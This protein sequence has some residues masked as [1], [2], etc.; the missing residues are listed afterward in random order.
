MHGHF[1]GP[2]DPVFIPASTKS[3]N[4][5]V[6]GDKRGDADCES[7]HTNKKEP[8][9]DVPQGQRA[10]PPP[11][12]AAAAVDTSCLCSGHACRRDGCNLGPSSDLLAGHS[13]IFKGVTRAPSTQYS[14]ESLR[15]NVRILHQYLS[16]E[17]PRKA[18]WL[19]QIA[20]A[21]EAAGSASLARQYY[22][23][24]FQET[25]SRS[26]AAW[27]MYSLSVSLHDE[28]D[29]PGVV[30][31]ASQGISKAPSP[32]LLWIASL[33]SYNMNNMQQA[34]AWAK[35]A[36]SLGCLQQK[37][38]SLCNIPSQL[39]FGDLQAWYALP[40]DVLVYAYKGLR[41][42]KTAVEDEATWSLGTAQWQELLAAAHAGD[43]AL[44]VAGLQALAA[45][46]E[47]EKEVCGTVLS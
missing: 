22:W 32:E 8:S 41:E 39:L 27:A 46:W 17:P 19:L 30:A 37:S 26:L 28:G 38:H 42:V 20:Q 2:V 23:K 31:A 7:C 14:G 15:Q 43:K 11:P 36:A 45:A 9:A 47:E 1:E 35:M 34:V 44:V 24:T 4:A 29:D 3:V 40:Y 6:L 10:P 21:Y 25:R 12:A 5:D 18:W 13:F 33:A 16:T